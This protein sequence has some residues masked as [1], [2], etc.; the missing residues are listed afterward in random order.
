VEV[1]SY[2]L[3]DRTGFFGKGL[4]PCLQGG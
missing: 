3:Q 1:I 2:P 4:E